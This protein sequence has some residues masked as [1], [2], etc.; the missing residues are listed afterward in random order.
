MAVAA[1]SDN[2]EIEA[3]IGY[4]EVEVG[5]HRIEIIAVHIHRVH[6]RGQGQ[7]INEITHKHVQKQTGMPWWQPSELIEHEDLGR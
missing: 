2:R 3:T 6:A 1:E 4:P 5:A 7:A